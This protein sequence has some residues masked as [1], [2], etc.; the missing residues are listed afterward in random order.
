MNKCRAD[1]LANGLI[2][3]IAPKAKSLIVTCFG[4]AVLPHGGACWLGSL[5][6][7]MRP[8]GLSD[9]LV[10]TCVFRLSKEDWLTSIP[11]GRRSL[12][13]V[14][15]TSRRRFEAADQRIYGGQQQGW[16]GE[17]TFVLASDRTRP[18]EP[19]KSPGDEEA[20]AD[21]TRQL[22]WIGF[23]EVGQR[24][25][26]HPVSNSEQLRLLFQ[27]LDMGQDAVIFRATA[28]TLTGSEPLR[29][30][31]RRIWNLEKVE[32]DYQAFLDMFR[33]VLSALSQAEALP[34]E[35]CFMVRTLLIH[36]YRRIVLRDPM[37]PEALLPG[38]WTGA[39]A[40]LLCR[41]LYRL[42]EARAERHLCAVLETA[43]GPVTKAHPP[44]FQRFGGLRGA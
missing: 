40:W 23:G 36:E 24:L 39:A 4:D 30:L 35:L 17:W 21:L 2:E 16:D 3:Q 12:Y 38:E 10:R 7:L 1:T 9:R 42:T 19:K 20:G 32:A 41:N 18:V 33:P 22:Q 31:A 34:G 11:V 44:Y 43:D 26:A 25:Y 15:E 6:R 5:I 27:N 13:T 8:F 14:T 37:L 29:A 28:E